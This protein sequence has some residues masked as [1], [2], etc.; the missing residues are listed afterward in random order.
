MKRTSNRKPALL[1]A[2]FLLVT[3]LASAA[4]ASGR[5]QVVASI[6]DLASIA[7]SVGGEDVEVAAIAR[8][9][10]DVHRVE[11]LPSYMVRVAR[12]KVYLKV[13]LALDQWADQIIDGSRNTKLAV[14]D[15]SRAIT[16][17]DK[18]AGRVDGRGGDV[19]PDGNP[20]YWLDPRNGALVATLLAG[21]FTRLDPAH[22]TG[23]Q[24]RAAAFGDSCRARHEA[25]KAA[26]AGLPTREIVTYHSSW[27]YFAAATGLSVAATVEPVPGIPP[28][29]GHLQKLVT[30]VKERRPVV[31]LQ[32][33]YFSDEA[34]GFLSR[35]TGL[36]TARVSPSCAEPVAGSYLA[37]FDAV[38][39]AITAGR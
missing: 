19:H 3:G 36:R 25:A 12:A 9:T 32:E 39:A 8:A 13:G 4:Q 27:V 29:G 1:F 34:A 11:V 20:H 24:A 10:S 5:L 31:L 26:L 33:P 6:N 22:A 37:H 2:A 35:E 15:C 18:P 7:A 16:A 38:V 14:I 30:L 17:L 23:F 21:E 28:T